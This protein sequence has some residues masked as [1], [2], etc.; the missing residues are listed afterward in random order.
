MTITARGHNGTVTFDGRFVTIERTGLLARTSVG[1]GEKRIPLKSIQAVQWKAP[2]ALVNGY[3]A[4]TIPGGNEQKSRAG[5]VTVDAAKDENAVIVTKK[6]AAAFLA[7]RE[8]VE[9]AIADL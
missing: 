2:G 1:K 7:L 9:A 8:A 4:F 6:Q 3:L 5:N